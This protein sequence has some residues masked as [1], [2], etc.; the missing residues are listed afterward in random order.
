MAWLTQSAVMTVNV[1]HQSCS[2]HGPYDCLELK[3]KL[4][5]TSELS[6]RGNINYMVTLQ[7]IK[8]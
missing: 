8:F 5:L 4:G 1:Y 6:Y 7:L 3:R 2:Q